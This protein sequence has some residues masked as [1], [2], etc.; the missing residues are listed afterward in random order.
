MKRYILAPIRVGQEVIRDVLVE[1]QTYNGGTVAHV[2]DGVVEIQKGY[3]VER[4]MIASVIKRELPDEEFVIP[5]AQPFEV[6]NRSSW[7][8][9]TVE[10]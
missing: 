10:D 6:L 5:Y 3:R 9:T 4:Y 1:G 8:L 2:K 7:R